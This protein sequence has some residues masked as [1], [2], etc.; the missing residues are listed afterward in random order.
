MP[1]A[2]AGVPPIWVAG[3]GPKALRCAGRIAD[4]VI[5]QFATSTSSNG[6]WGSCVEGA[7]AAGRD[8]SAIRVMSAT[9]VWVSDDLVQAR[10]Q[11][12]WF[13]ALVSNHVVDLVS[14]YSQRT[15]PKS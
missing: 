13:P 11:V 7:E 12:R 8:F 4:G 10:E 6:V 9:A 14:R 3:Y 15:S 2:D 1:W 5:L